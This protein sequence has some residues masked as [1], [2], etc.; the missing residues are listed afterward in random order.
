MLWLA[1]NQPLVLA[2]FERLVHSEDRAR[3][4]TAIDSALA[5]NGSGDF[6]AEFRVV[7]PA[8][9]SERWIASHGKTE[10]KDG[11]PQ[12]LIG[13]V[14]DVTQRRR[15]EEMMRRSEAKFSG[16]VAIAADAIISVDAE[17]RITLFNDGAER[18]FGYARGDLIGKPLDVLIP[19]R[20]RVAHA[21]HVRSFGQ[22]ATSA[23]RM[24]ERAE[25]FGLRNNGEEFAAEASISHLEIGGETIYTVVLRDISE[26]KRAEELLARS[27]S[28]L[29]K[30]VNERTSEL[31]AE[32]Q[33]REETQALLVRAQRMEAFGQLTGGIAHDFNNLLTVV[34]GNLELLDLRLKDEKDKTLL[35][36]A[37]DAAEMGSRLT[38]RLL[39]VARRRQ[40]ETKTINLN[41]HVIGM[42]D[43]LR[44]TLGE[45]IDLTTR[46]A[47]KL[48]TVRA[49]PSEVENA[50]LNLA[51]NARDAMPRGGRLTVETTNTT[52]SADAIGH[53]R[54]LPAGDYV[55]LAVADTGMGMTADV[56]AHA[57]EPFFTTKQPGK[58]TGLGLSTLYGFVQQQGG[59]VTIASTPGQGTTVK[60]YLPKAS[61]DGTLLVVDSAADNVPTATG[62]T[63]LLV[64]DNPE[65]RLVTRERLLGLG[66]RVI[67]VENGPAALDVLKTDRPIDLV[68]SDVVMA[69]GMSGIDVARWVASNR[70]TLK[71]LLTSGYA[72][73]VLRAQGGDADAFKILRKPYN[74]RELA[75]SLRN[76]LNT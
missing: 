46:L 11:R 74:R 70:P 22:S 39:T 2:T 35:K 24:G 43:L 3:W 6:H 29:E 8:D 54:K 28:E 48:W 9:G 68:F 19:V 44:R 31:R 72:D 26:R 41:E 1:P 23:R 75:E 13:V 55:C 49:D 52:I 67:D 47:P 40:L 58:G 62:E 60:V 10:F 38:E 15:A 14:R 73:D 12:R 30:R 65:V 18:I 37:Q 36:R 57:F 61:A 27:H 76:V 33:R 53:D 64:E 32:M 63:V 4:Q 69:G 7:H 45:P 16:I 20:F 59:T 51:I 21:G 34:T 17:Q 25:I 42:A 66:Y 56:L 71:T 50:L 5:P